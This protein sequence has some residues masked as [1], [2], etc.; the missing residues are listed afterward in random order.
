MAKSKT[1]DPV[2][3]FHRDA[4][5]GHALKV[6]TGVRNASSAAAAGAGYR[7]AVFWVQAVGAAEFARRATEELL[8]DAV[9]GARA[10]GAS[11]ADVGRELGITKQAAQQRLGSATASANARMSAPQVEMLDL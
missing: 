10:A 7:D 1:V 2:M 3:A 9:A 6:D 11:W 8:V 4:L 5:F